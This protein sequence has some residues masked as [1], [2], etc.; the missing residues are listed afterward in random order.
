[1]HRLF[2]AASCQGSASTEPV[3]HVRGLVRVPPLQGLAASDGRESCHCA[4]LRERHQGVR[5]RGK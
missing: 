4:A 2:L 5:V 1:M 3:V